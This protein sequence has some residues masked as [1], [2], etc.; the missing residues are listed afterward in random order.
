MPSK[1]ELLEENDALIELLEEIDEVVD[2][3]AEI[4]ERVDEALTCD[5]EDE[6]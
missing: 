5:D 3:P 2:L 1:Q 6:D 4:Q